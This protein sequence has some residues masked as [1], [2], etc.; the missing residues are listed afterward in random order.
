[1]SKQK[2]P[3]VVPPLS[4]I[5]RKI[6]ISFVVLTVLLV[7]IIVFFSMSKATVV[8][9]PKKEIR[10]AEFLVT[11]IEGI[12]VAGDGSGTISGKYEEKIMEEEGQFESTQLETREGRATGRVTLMNTSGVAQPL[13]ATTRLLSP[14]NVLFRMKSGATVP[15]NGSVEVEVYADQPGSQGDIGPTRFTIPGLNAAKQKLI[16]GESKE[17]MQGSSG[18]M[19]VVGA[20]DLERAK[21]EVA[22]KA[23]KKAQ[24]DARQSANAAGFQ[25]LMA[26]HE[27]LEATANARAGE[28]KQTF[29]IKVKVRAKLLAYDKMQL[30]ILAL[31]KVK[32]AIPVDRELVVFNG[33]AMILRLKNVDTQ[34]GEVQ[35]QVYAD[36]EVRITPSSPILDPAKIAGMMPEEAERY[37]QS[38]DAIERVEIRLFPSWQK[39]IPTIPDRVK[40]VMKR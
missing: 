27:I 36:G 16:Y 14:S 29:T 31:N 4:T 13:V 18:Q 34:R 38:F 25:G 6:A 33:E 9:T 32:E 3:I 1:M 39:R 2:K 17:A 15:A 40:I 8:I 37:L 12:T 10:S 11:V 20:A 35:L 21:A 24:D 7:G 19:R 26:S 28:A 23:V 22:E 30:E 5:Y